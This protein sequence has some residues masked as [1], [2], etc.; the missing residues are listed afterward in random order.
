[1]TAGIYKIVNNTNGKLYIGSSNN[2][3]KR[4]R[5]HQSLL[6]NGKH[7]N[8][9]LQHAFNIVSGDFSFSILEVC[10]IEMLLLQEKYFIDIL[11]TLNP[12]HGFNKAPHPN[13][14]TRGLKWSE[15]SKQKLSKTLLDDYKSG[16]R[17]GASF[18]HSNEAKDQI[19]KAGVGRI[20]QNRKKIWCHQA[21][22]EY[23]SIHFA[24]RALNLS[25]SGIMDVLSK[26]LRSIK[27]YTFEYAD[28]S[29]R[30]VRTL[31]FKTKKVMCIDTGI[32]Y[33]SKSEA[34]SAIS[35]RSGDVGR[36]IKNNKKIKGLL[37]KEVEK[38][39]E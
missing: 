7:Y 5:Y 16:R 29:N 9:H 4:L 30:E 26:N 8:K 37:F 12:I 24:A 3:E 14:G 31:V 18:L 1:M 19:S 22:A 36:A 39:D 25:I 17:K 15:E 20:P 28:L 27:G 21:A 11:N 34:A 13:S 2:I 38:K 33:K 6:N 32:I 23:E 35:V 10:N